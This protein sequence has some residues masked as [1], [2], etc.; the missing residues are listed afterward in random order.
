MMSVCYFCSSGMRTA[1]I[2]YIRA[3]RRLALACPIDDDLLAKD[4]QSRT[5]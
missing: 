2:E 3:L 4:G 5:D 1:G